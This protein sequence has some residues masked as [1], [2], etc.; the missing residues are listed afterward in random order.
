M[1]RL[2][3]II[4]LGGLLAGCA[5]A[6]DKDRASKEWGD[7]VA[8]AVIRLDDGKS[9]PSSIA[10]GVAPVCAVQYQ[11]LTDMMVSS[12]ITDVGQA[13]AR[14]DMRAGEVRLITSAVLIHR[15]KAH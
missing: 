8:A 14:Q 2:L 15:Q 3:A 13:Y 12:N 1:T 5:S 10:Y 9:D 7:C 6:A 11:R 4:G